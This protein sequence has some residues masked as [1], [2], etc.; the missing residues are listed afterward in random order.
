MMDDSEHDGGGGL[1]IDGDD[2][3]GRIG[4]DL[5]TSGME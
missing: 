5:A 4:D 1:D 3:D 2:I